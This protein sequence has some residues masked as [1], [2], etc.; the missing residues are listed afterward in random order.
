MR[1]YIRPDLDVASFFL[2]LRDDQVDYVVLRWFEALPE[3]EPGEDIDILVRA[4]DLEKLLEFVSKDRS[5]IPLDIYTEDGTRGTGWGESLVYP[6]EI[7]ERLLANRILGRNG[8]FRP[9]E[10]DYFFSLA[11]H[12]VF[13]KGFDS[14]LGSNPVI[15]DHDYRAALLETRGGLDVKEEVMTLDGLFRFLWDNQFAPTPDMLDI[16]TRRN[17]W[18]AGM[19]ASLLDG[20]Q[21]PW[22]HVSLFIVRE[23]GLDM[24]EAIRTAVTRM[25]FLVVKDLT[26]DAHQSEWI[27]TNVRGGNWGRG[28]Y[29]ESGGEPRHVIIAYDPFPLE[30]TAKVRTS[31][32]SLKNLREW[33]TKV[34]LRKLFIGTVPRSKRA[35]IV[36]SVDNGFH[37]RQLAGK[38]LGA[39]GVADLESEVQRKEI[40]YRIPFQEFT[41]IPTGRK[42]AVVLETRLDD[43]PVIVKW[44][45]PGAEK[46]LQRELSV[47]T[48]LGHSAP[49]I[50]AIRVG[51][52]WFAM[53]KVA[54]VSLENREA[55]PREVRQILSFVSRVRQFGFQPID[56][57]PKN[58]IRRPNGQLEFFDFEYF[59]EAE[60]PHPRESNLAFFDPPKDSPYELP[61]DA[62]TDL[63]KKRWLNALLIPRWLLIREPSEW[64]ISAAQRVTQLTLVV[65]RAWSALLGMGQ[66][67]LQR[68]KKSMTKTHAFKYLSIPYRLLVSVL[69]ARLRLIGGRR[70]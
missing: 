31:H 37:A 36:H 3:V 29:P 35:N 40:D 6:K 53:K 52:N 66:K 65:Q 42:R 41:L 38:L 46:Y 62:R 18:L 43:I 45:K 64:L 17:P 21:F 56:F 7:S 50:P 8:V 61:M 19:W 69:P 47:R 26:L 33:H 22:S 59:Q 67:Q 32:P 48:A 28:P 63:Y 51:P 14:G 5:G 30:P 12:V 1:R 20:V 2:N 55:T 54:G 44:F 60:K 9:T 68:Y 23:R 49:V 24:L 27:A 58:I 39:Q 4:R 10:T 13:H 16:Y 25:G 34:L 57:F 11:Y 15:A 70:R